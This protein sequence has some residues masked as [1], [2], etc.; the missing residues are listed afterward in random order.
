MVEELIS[1]SDR[2][3]GLNIYNNIRRHFLNSLFGFIMCSS[4]QQTK[5]ERRRE[6]NIKEKEWQ[7]NKTSKIRK[8][9]KEN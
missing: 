5:N 4:N 8:K 3:G 1:V 6:T 9:R 7:N 2:H